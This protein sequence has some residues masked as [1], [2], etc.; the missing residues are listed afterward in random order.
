M[1]LSSD[2]VIKR[3]I[4]DTL[5]VR[6]GRIFL[7]AFPQSSRQDQDLFSKGGLTFGYNNVLYGS[8][9]ACWYINEKWVDGYDGTVVDKKPVIAL[10]GTDALNRKSSG[11]AQYQRFHHALGAVRNGVIGIYY[12]KKGID[13]IRPDL[14]GI[15]YFASKFEKGDYLVIDDLKIVKDILSLYDSP[16]KLKNYVSEY[17]NSMFFL[18]N[19]EFNKLYGGN[20]KRFA[21]KRS[22]VI[23]DDYVIKYAARMKRNF[24]EASQ[25]AGHIAVGEM[26]ITKYY[27]YDKKVYYL[28]LKMTGDEL[29]YLDRHKVDDKEWRILRHEPNVVI[30]T[31]D[32]IVGLSPGIRNR[33]MMI[34]D[35]PLSGGE[36]NGIYNECSKAIFAGLKNGSLQI[37][38]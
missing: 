21:D 3:E 15:A 6:Y 26:Y 31:I 17:L 7:R 36:T 28:F 2:E 13:R 11:N 25:R 9:D 23:K 22:T 34:K 14:F 30:R 10:E 1:A 37:R 29:A 20:W 33:L 5:G 16:L 18:F 38:L 12:L 4:V 27:F 35:K 8:C 24:T 32:D 19:S